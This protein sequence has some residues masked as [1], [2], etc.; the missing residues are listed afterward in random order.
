MQ[1]L[2]EDEITWDLY[3]SKK[4]KGS[5][6]YFKVK[7]NVSTIRDWSYYCA[8]DVDLLEVTLD[9]SVIAYEIKGQR[10]RKGEPD[11]PALYDGLGQALAYL[12]LPSVY[13]SALKK[14]LFDG[15][16]FDRVYLVNAR[17]AGTID[18]ESTRILELTPIGY[19]AA[20]ENNRMDEIRKPAVNPLKSQDAKNH[21]LENLPTLHEFSEES[22]TFRNLKAKFGGLG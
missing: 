5:K 16:A 8:P 17:P 3:K 2:T 1:L 10:M 22:R 20:Y 4:T 11:W 6:L 13:S 12:M 7:H 14:R 15:G 18:K 21:L 19:I 9:N